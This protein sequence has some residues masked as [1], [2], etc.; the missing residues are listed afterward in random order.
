MV[1]D[2]V[3][4]IKGIGLDNDVVAGSVAERDPLPAVVSLAGPAHIRDA[5]APFGIHMALSLAC[6]TFFSGSK[7][8]PRGEIQMPKPCGNFLTEGYQRSSFT[9]SHPSSSTKPSKLHMP[10]AQRPSVFSRYA[11]QR[12][13]RGVIPAVVMEELVGREPRVLVP[14]NKESRGAAGFSAIRPAPCRTSGHY[15]GS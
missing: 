3:Q 14:D 5:A 2:G 10:G 6:Y 1:H 7:Y 8:P 11:N 4:G 13:L 15:R 12:F 9:S